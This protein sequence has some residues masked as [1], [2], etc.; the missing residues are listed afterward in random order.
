MSL[1]ILCVFSGVVLQVKSMNLDKVVNFP[2]PTPPNPLAL[3]QAEKVP[4]PV[5]DN[6]LY[7]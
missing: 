6:G 1:G 5:H 2:F 3:A 4:T 7:N